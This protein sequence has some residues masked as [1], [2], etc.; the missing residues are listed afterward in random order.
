MRRIIL[1]PFVIVGG[2]FLIV[3]AVML[4]VFRYQT[5][6]MIPVEGVI[7]AWEG[8]HPVI[9]YTV[10]GEECTASIG[11]STSVHRAVGSP[12]RLMADPDHPGHAVDY[13][14]VLMGCIFG[15]IALVHLAIG[16]ILWRVMGR[17]ERMRE[18]L[19]QY[20]L[21]VSAVISELRINRSVQVNNRHPWVAVATCVHPSTREKVTVRSHLLW[22]PTVA[23]GDK[24]DVLFDP[25][26]ERRYAMDIP[27]EKR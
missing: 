19:R 13:F 14:L 11:I 1:L 23:E 4:G 20:G 24:V 8:D 10:S 15:G 21:R 5:A 3:A 9:S 26:D 17:R 6:D 12:Y 7:A 25:M 2:T 18:E 22:N 27:E 16:F